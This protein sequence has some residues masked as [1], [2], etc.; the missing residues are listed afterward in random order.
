MARDLI[1]VSDKMDDPAL[2][3]LTFDDG[4]RCQFE[5]ALPIL[6]GY[7]FHA[8]FFL[9]ANQEQTHES[10]LNHTNDWWKI[11]WREDDIAMLKELIKKGHEI[12]SHSV[13]HHPS[14]MK[15]QPDF[16]ARESKRLIEVW[17]A[18][19]VSSFCYP[20][21]RSH[22]YLSDAV[23]QAG[24]EQAR[25][26]GGRPNYGPRA[27]YYAMPHDATL[28]RLNVDC[29]QIA[30]NENVSTW[31]RPGC[32]HVLTYHG[33]GTERD[34]WEPITAEE[35]SKQMSELAKLRESGAAKIV[36]FKKGADRFR[37]PNLH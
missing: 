20:F 26:G 24:Y 15:K 14:K 4:F 25:G 23:M 33:I 9:I 10:W 34:G 28:D 1:L 29:R 27:S 19:E 36:T 32:W 6:D 18:S 11:D 3:S 7:G 22:V 31:V 16:E 37:Q 5:K 17:L 2:I 13:T 35:F 8:T 21:Y 30:R 12:G